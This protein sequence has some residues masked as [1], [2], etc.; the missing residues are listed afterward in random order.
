MDVT[1][2]NRAWK[3]E[4][5]FGSEGFL[6]NGPGPCREATVP[7]KWVSAD[8][9]TCNTPSFE[10]YGPMEVIVR[11]QLYPSLIEI[12]YQEDG[13]IFDRPPFFTPLEH[14]YDQNRSG[15]S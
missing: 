2:W 3:K 14:G 8:Q 15:K 13:L 6:V 9:V 5:M 10:K 12:T 7:G 1:C 11:V 4:A